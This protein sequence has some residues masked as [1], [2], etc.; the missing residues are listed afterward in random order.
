VEPKEPLILGTCGRRGPV[1]TWCARVDLGLELIALA[2]LDPT[3][4]APLKTQFDTAIRVLLCD[5]CGAPLEVGLGAGSVRCKHCGT[6]STFA[7]RVERFVIEHPRVPESYRLG[8]L[9]RQD[10]TGPPTPPAYRHLLV[11]GRVPSW[12][13]DE[14]MRAWLRARV[15]LRAGGVD[16]AERFLFL[17]TMMSSYLFESRDYLRLRAMYESALEAVELP[18]HKQVLRGFLSRTAASLGDLDAAERW[19]APCDPFAHELD[20][21]GAYRLSRAT[22]ATAKGEWPAVLAWLG[23]T[24]DE[25]PI[26]DHYDAL[27]VVLRAHALEALGRLDLA[28][29]ALRLEMQRGA[30][31]R[32]ALEALVA[33][34]P[35]FGLCPKSLPAA[36]AEFLSVAE[37]RTA[38]QGAGSHHALVITVLGILAIFALVAAINASGLLAALALALLV[39]L[40]LACFVVLHRAQ[41]ASERARRVAREG[42]PARGRVIEVRRDHPDAIP[43]GLLDLRLEVMLPGREP[44]EALVRGVASMTPEQVLAQGELQL[45]VDP[46]RPDQV[47]IVW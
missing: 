31:A 29:A 13:L 14:A 27:A 7:A 23:N 25:V 32:D 34:S 36:R 40:V 39:L 5:H 12:H 20:A 46:E 28:V 16:A 8:E 42:L 3:E 11:G 30:G 44:Y 43:T 26:H 1:P 17:T 37:A 35:R 19:L 45:K 38:T 4:A 6:H 33:A 10:F 9:R 18:R 22:L 15:E 21:D 47:V 2:P 24:R 41:R